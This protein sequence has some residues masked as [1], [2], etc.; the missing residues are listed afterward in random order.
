M[1]NLSE[2]FQIKQIAEMDTV[3]LVR[4]ALKTTIEFIGDG[5]PSEFVRG[6]MRV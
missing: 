5:E 3:R 2:D 1:K 4:F 6:W